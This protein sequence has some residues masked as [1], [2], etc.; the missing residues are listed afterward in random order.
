MEGLS[1]QT[2]QIPLGYG[3]GQGKDP[4][5]LNPPELTVFKDGECDEHGGLQTR[6]V[7]VAKSDVIYNGDSIENARRVVRNGSE[8]LLFTDTALYSWSES[9]A[10]WVRKGTHLAIKLDETPRFATT[11][12]QFECDRAELDGTVFYSWKEGDYGYIAAMDAETGSVLLAPTQVPGYRVR[13]TALET[14]VLLSYY[15][16][17]GGIYCYALDPAVPILSGVP[18]T[19]SNGGGGASPGPYH[20]IV[21]QPGADT[22]VFVVTASGTGAYTIGHVTAGLSVTRST[23]ARAS[24]APIAVACDPTGTHAQVVRRDLTNIEGDLITISTL[25]DVYTNQAI[26]TAASS[27]DQITCAYSSNDFG[28]GV[29]RAYV[30]WETNSTIKTSYA[31]T[32]NTIGDEEVFVAG[33]TNI[34]SRAFGH[35]GHVFVW[36]VFATAS[37]FFSGGYST[38]YAY[39]LQNTYFLYRDEG[40]L[41]AKATSGVAGGYQTVGHLPGVVSTGTNQYAWCGAERRVI[42]IGTAKRRQAYADRGPRDIVFTFDSNEARR[43]AR[44][45]ETLYIACS[46]GLLQYDGVQLTEVGFH[47]FLFFLAAAEKATGSLANGTYALKMGLRWQNARGEVDRSTSATVGEVVIASGPGG[48]DLQWSQIHWTHKTTPAIAAEVWR[49]EVNPPDAAPFYLA[50]DKDPSSITNPN[51]Y[52]TVDTTASAGDAF[53]DE[54]VDADLANGGSHPENGAVLEYLAP[55][56]ASIVIAS[57]DRLFLAGVAGDPDRVWY[58]RQ[59]GSNEVAS[60]HETLTIA[61]PRE[62]GA[63]TGLAFLNETLIVFRETAVYALPGDGYDNTGGGSNYGPARSISDDLGAE[64]P[65]A[66][67]LTPQGLVFHSRK[68]KYLLGR[69]WN[70][71]HIGEAVSDYDDEPVLAVHVLEDK[72]QIR[73]LT[74]NRL[75]VLDYEAVTETS[76]I[77]QWGEWTVEDG[78]HATI[79]DGQYVCLTEAGVLEQTSAFSGV[80]YG[81]D[82]TTAWIKGNDLQ[83]AGRVRRVLVLGE[84]RGAFALKVELYRDYETTPFQTKWWAPS[85]TTIGGP[86]QFKIGPSKQRFQALKVRV[87]AVDAVDSDA[88]PSTEALK[89][90]GLALEVGIYPGL[91]RQ[92]PA[93]QKV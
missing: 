69:G 40:F 88:P 65:E 73:W 7:L 52:L 36:L 9:L 59:R 62:G 85:P 15:D 49:T 83:G 18:V 47:I 21:K 24:D 89:L 5:V 22:A 27:P 75:L 13:L 42:P 30:Y 11:G 82:V 67:A 51:R 61:V 53:E 17:V 77:G 2:F 79:W 23:K 93:A 1:W 76:P 63:I 41:A 29:Y 80:D 10:A 6:P 8:L 3:L 28:G 31:N 26:G 91:H 4:R 57:A 35:D 92:L 71:Q 54:L 66:I 14:V 64:S 48:V 16:G 50:S 87:T 45:G 33:S 46:E 58:S 70:L 19:L 90:S 32:N 72:H 20:D 60:F 37:S 84:Y 55:P 38:Q 34:A 44:L 12:D 25:A 86:L 43:C 39:Q 68:G 78:L 56:A 81:L 74:A